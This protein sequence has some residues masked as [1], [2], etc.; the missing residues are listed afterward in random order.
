MCSLYSKS[1]CLLLFLKVTLFAQSVAIIQ[2]FSAPEIDSLQAWL[3]EMQ[4]VN[5]VYEQGEYTSDSLTVYDVIIWDDL[6]YAYGGFRSDDVLIFDD[7]H[8]Q[9]KRLYFI[10]DDLGINV[11]CFIN[12][13]ED[14]IITNLMH[15]AAD[16]NISGA[17]S[18]VVSDS[19]HPVISG[20]FGT[21]ESFSAYIDPDIAL[22]TNTGEKVLMKTNNGYDVVVAFED[23]V[24]NRIVSQNT[25]ALKPGD[26]GQ[27]N[28]KTL[29]KNSINWLMD[30][31]TTIEKETIFTPYEF[32]LAQNYP[33]PFNPVT[34]ID[35]SISKSSF[36]IIKIYNMLGQEISTIVDKFK[37][38]GN[39]YVHF[40]P[41]NMSSG[42]YYYSMQLDNNIVAVKKMLL[43]K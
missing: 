16:V 37:Y 24:G 40:N 23:S 42:V 4:I 29:F 8:K 26:P 3:N 11:T 30:S 18:I 38:P 5:K 41:G 13:P 36:V 20:P 10:G 1:I 25:L 9:G 7:I 33:N 12:Y 22:A 15:I 39:H 27:I 32:I 21:V 28:R 14:S 2:N 35:Y 43:I 17:D 34:T 19:M 6:S 31:V